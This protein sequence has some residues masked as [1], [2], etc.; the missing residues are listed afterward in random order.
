MRHSNFRRRYFRPAVAGRPASPRR[1]GTGGREAIRGALP[2]ELHG[3]RF[4]DLRHCAAS[5]AAAN[6]AQPKDVQR[7][8]GHSSV[9]ITMDRYTH[10][11][12]ERQE[13]LAERMDAAFREAVPAPVAEVRELRAAG[14]Q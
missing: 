1:R 10:L 7:M 9:Q 2:E 8:L 13:A 12:P 14:E 11:F 3:L 5:I 6:G 4:H